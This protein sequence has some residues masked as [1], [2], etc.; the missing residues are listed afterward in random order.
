METTDQPQ[1]SIS[2]TRVRV[3]SSWRAL[4]RLFFLSVLLVTL[5]SSKPTAYHFEQ[6][7][8]YLVDRQVEQGKLQMLKKLQKKL[9]KKMVKTS[10]SD[11]FFFT[12]NTMRVGKDSYV[13]IGLFSGFLPIYIE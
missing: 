12:L 2:R 11:F 6:F 13:F 4:H 7:R 10:T 8:D 1:P 3:F 9:G 5:Q